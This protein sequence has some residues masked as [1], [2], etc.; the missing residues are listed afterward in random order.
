MAVAQTLTP[1]YVKMA[2]DQLGE[3]QK[4]LPAHIEALRR[5]LTS[6]PHITC[7]TG[8]IYFES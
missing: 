5:W 1:K 6:M 2:K 4:N 7:P 3:D 8:K